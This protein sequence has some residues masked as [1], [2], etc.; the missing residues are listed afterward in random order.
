MPAD[1]LFKLSMACTHQAQSLLEMGRAIDAL[2]TNHR[3]EA[4]LPRQTRRL[5]IKTLVKNAEL[6]DLTAVLLDERV[7]IVVV[8][9]P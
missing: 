2:P 1:S 9:R 3:G 7:P 6:L 4:I 8:T 5:M